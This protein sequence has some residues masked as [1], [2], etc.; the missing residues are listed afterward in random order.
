M[1]DVDFSKLPLPAGVAA[2]PTSALFLAFTEGPA[3]DAD[4]TVYFSDIRTIAFS[5]GRP[6]ARSRSFASRAGGRTATRSIAKV[7]CCIA[8]GP[9]SGPA[10]VDASRAPI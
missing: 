6:T 9:S 4:G 2:A 5:N 7:A 1:P 3:C 8:K 10:A